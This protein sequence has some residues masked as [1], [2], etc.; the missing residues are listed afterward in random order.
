MCIKLKPGFVKGYL[1]KVNSG[2]VSDGHNSCCP[3]A[4]LAAC[5]SSPPFSHGDGPLFFTIN[6]KAN[7]EY[8]MEELD[9]AVATIREGLKKDAKFSELTKLLLMVKAG[10]KKA[11]STRDKVKVEAKNSATMGSAEKVNVL[12]AAFSK[13]ITDAFEKVRSKSLYLRFIIEPVLIRLPCSSLDYRLLY[14]NN[15][16]SSSSSST[17]QRLLLKCL[18]MK[19]NGRPLQRGSKCVGMGCHLH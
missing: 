4:P 6:P 15:R 16:S 8:L 1:R 7:A 18:K 14:F 13:K 3:F 17:Q 10:K 11:A 12:T 5:S 9:S 2:W 19:W